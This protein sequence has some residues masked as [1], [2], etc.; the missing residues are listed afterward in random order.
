MAPARALCVCMIVHPKLLRP[1][2][3]SAGAGDSQR[4]DLL[5]HPEQLLCLAERNFDGT[6]PPLR[7]LKA[8]RPHWFSFTTSA[9]WTH[10]CVCRLAL[11]QAEGLCPNQQSEAEGQR[12]ARR[13]RLSLALLQR[14]SLQRRRSI[15]AQRVGRGG[16]RVPHPSTHRGRG[17]TCDDERHRWEWNRALRQL[18]ERLLLLNQPTTSKPW[19]KRKPHT[20][21]QTSIFL[22]SLHTPFQSSG[23][24]PIY[25]FFFL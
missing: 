19:S 25:Y 20:L 24:E 5:G 10:V 13:L 21:W 4:R 14:C 12:V 2:S 7:K 18:M 3:P 17:K 1:V 8:S 11:R 6:K 15:G 23:L 22:G 16:C 9:T